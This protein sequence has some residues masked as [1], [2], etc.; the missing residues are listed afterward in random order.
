MTK[1]ILF[2]ALLGGVLSACSQMGQPSVNEA[3]ILGCEA[4]C[5][6]KGLRMEATHFQREG[7]CGCKIDVRVREG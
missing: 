1:T 6:A 4:E 2:S 7:T 5:H 3:D